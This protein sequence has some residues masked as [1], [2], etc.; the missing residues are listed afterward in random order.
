MVAK[1]I[2]SA[3]SSPGHIL[4]VQVNGELSKEKRSAPAAVSKGVCTWVEDALFF[5][6]AGVGVKEGEESLGAEGVRIEVTFGIARDRPVHQVSYAKARRRIEIACQ[7]FATTVAPFGILYPATSSSSSVFRATTGTHV[8][9]RLGYR[10][11]GTGQGRTERCD[12]RP[13]V[14]LEDQRADVW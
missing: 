8:N 11:Q 1:R 4:P 3:K 5:G 14:Q 12:G 2:A 13:A 9:N 7:L 10:V 6:G